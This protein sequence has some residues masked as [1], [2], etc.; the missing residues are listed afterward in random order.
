LPK[1]SWINLFSGEKTTGPCWLKDFDC[2][3]KDMPVW[4][5][6]GAS[7]PVYPE[8]VACTDDMDFSKVL[9]IPMN[10]TFKGIDESVL[11]GLLHE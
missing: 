3:L 4:V 11:A 10:E 7:I 8:A 2:P 1:G 6:E 9:Q 5:R